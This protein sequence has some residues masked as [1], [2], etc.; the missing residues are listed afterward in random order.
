MIR[1]PHSARISRPFSQPLRSSSSKGSRLSFRQV[2]AGGGSE[3]ADPTPSEPP[4]SFGGKVK[5]WF[6]SQKQLAVKLKELGL[7]AI[8]AYGLFDAVTY[9][10]FFYIAFTAYEAQ[11]GINPT[12][13]V[14]AVIQILLGMWLAN[15]TTRPFRV[16]GAALISPAI[17]KMLK[18]R[19]ASN[20]FFFFH[21][22]SA[23]S[24]GAFA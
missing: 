8:L 14:K 2:R 1:S 17:S 3:A 15:N 19:F 4:K 9:T 20:V 22:F 5:D 18:V 12:T 21:Y 23:A 11:T 24:V 16:G 13:N 10:T 6:A 7:S